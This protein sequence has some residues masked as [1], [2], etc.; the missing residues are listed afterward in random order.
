MRSIGRDIGINIR[1]RAAELAMGGAMC[2][3]VFVVVMQ[4]IDKM[5]KIG[6]Q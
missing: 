2:L 3:A 4:S 5:I 6:T 1:V